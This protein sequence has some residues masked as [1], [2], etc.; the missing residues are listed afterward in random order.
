[1][2]PSRSTSALIALVL[3]CT[4][5]ARAQDP[6]REPIDSTWVRAHYTKREVTISVR[7]GVR[8]FTSI[9]EP[10]D[11]SRAYPILIRR[12]PYSLRPYGPDRV[13]TSL[14]PHDGFARDGFIFVYQD[15]RGRWMSE[16]EFV[17]VR[18]H[19]ARKKSR[20]D[21]D[22]STDTYDTI[23][24]LLKN[25]RNHNGRVGMWGISYPG[26]YTSA[27][28]INAHPALRAASPQAPIADWFFD[29]F[30]HHG[31]FFLPHAFGFFHFFGQPRPG[32]TTEP[33]ANLFDYGTP[34]GYEFYLKLGPLRNVDEKYFQGRVAFWNE[35]AA[36]PNRDAFWQARNIL[37]HLRKVAPAVMTV[38]GWFDAEDLYGTLQTY[39]AL[40]RQNP[41]IFNIL[42]MGPWFH[43]GWARSDGQSLGDAWFQEKTAVF[44]RD[45][46]EL[47]FFRHFLKDDADPKLP[48]AFVF[49]TG[50]NRWRRLDTWPPAE[51][52]ELQLYLREEG[53]LSFTPPL[54]GA[55]DFDAF[56]EY[57]SDPTRP[58]PFTQ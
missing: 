40:E 42:V 36:H 28:M 6:A 34:D 47:P 18:P 3:V 26:F 13:P 17:N 16:G 57:V 8:L 48:E 39:R 38:G 29:D 7:D 24:W 56:D 19:S 55:T 12:T 51:V 54:P 22:E 45:S 52:V 15:V 11:R 44:Y 9:Y 37:P 41:G 58:V 1:M 35:I 43:G 50:A 53:K 20:K 46:I 32:P 33:P 49:E 21:I 25:V 30:F 10:R 4:S 2:R 23:E 14:G 5:A 31:A 27:G